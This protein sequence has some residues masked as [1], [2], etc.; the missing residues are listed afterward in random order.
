VI[1]SFFNRL[2]R[3]RDQR[4]RAEGDPNPGSAAKKWAGGPYAT[5]ARS[6]AV[7]YSLLKDSGSGQGGG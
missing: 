5:F 7:Y 4:D 3:A 1:V 6:D 2:V